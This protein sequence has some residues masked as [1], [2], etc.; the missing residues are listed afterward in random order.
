MIEKI[1]IK[2]GYHKLM[3]SE[4]FLLA[5]VVDAWMNER[6]V[7]IDYVK[8]TQTQKIYQKIGKKKI[9]TDEIKWGRD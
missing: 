1:L 9:M 2:L 6:D 7:F 4:K 8:K 3:Q 5:A